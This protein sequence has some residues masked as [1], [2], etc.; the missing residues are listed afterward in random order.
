MCQNS[1]DR[2]AVGYV[3]HTLVELGV[4]PGY[5]KVRQLPHPSAPLL[6]SLP[7]R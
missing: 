3:A 1:Y 4:Q 2:E 7:V 6:V 5:Y